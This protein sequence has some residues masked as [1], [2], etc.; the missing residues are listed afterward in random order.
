[1]E[2]ELVFSLIS[3]AKDEGLS[4]IEW[5]AHHQAVGFDKI[6]IATNNCSDGT[7]DLVS[8]LAKFGIVSHLEN[9]VPPNKFPQRSAYDTL[10]DSEFVRNSDWLMILDLDEF[11]NVHSGDVNSP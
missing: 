6:L 10:I 8:E 9:I 7:D 2:S 4:I 11:I 5:V 3:C 1:L